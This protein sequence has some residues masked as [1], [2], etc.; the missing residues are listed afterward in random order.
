MTD[1]QAN[2]EAIEALLERIRRLE[3]AYQG[4][5]ISAVEEKWTY[6]GADAAV[7]TYNLTV[8]GDLAWKYGKG[9]R[10][11]LKQAGITS[12]F[13]VTGVAYSAPSTTLTI[14][15]G[16]DYSLANSRIIEPYFSM[17]KTPYGFPVDEAKWR[18]E[19]LVTADS[20]QASPVSG[21]WYNKGGSLAIPIGR[22]R[23]EYAA[24]L[25]VTRAAAGALDV[26]ATLSTAA[27]SE[28]DKETT[29]KIGISSGTSMRGSVSHC[30]YLLDLAAKATYYLNCKT[31]QASM[32]AITFK[33]SEQKT[34]VRAVCAYL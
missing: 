4:G 1:S 21:T 22:W 5:W 17:A 3:D 29:T 33:G 28:V 14:F 10:V 6:A 32:T 23:V 26:F 11:R 18:V 2:S 19:S 8:P 30:G 12:Y 9:M 20:S 27:S 34:K 13:I 16:T 31:G 7:K 25:E 15:G 24:E